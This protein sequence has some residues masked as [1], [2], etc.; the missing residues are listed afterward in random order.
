MLPNAEPR[1]SDIFI[2][3]DR[4]LAVDPDV[5][6]FGSREATQVVDARGC[7]VMPG[8]INAHTHTPMTLTRSTADDAGFPRPGDAP[9]FPPGKDW[10]GRLTAEDHYWSSRLAIAEMIRG[11]TTTFVDMYHDMDRVAQAVADTGIRAALG[12]EIVTFRND[13]REWLPYDE[14]TAR[15]TFEACGQFAADW[16]GKGDGR[17]TALVA[18]HET[19]TCHEPWLSRCARLAGEMN[20][21]ITI[22]VA[23]S[24]WEVGVCQDRYG[25][26]PVQTLERTGILEHRVLGAHSLILTD[27]DIEILAGARYSA[28]AC[29]GC[30]LKLAMGV[31]PVPRLLRAGVNVALGTDGA[32]TN[33]NLN[34]WDEIHLNATLHGFLA[35]D[36]TMIP[37]DSAL[38]MAT[39]GGARALGLE[40]ELGVIAPGWKADLIVLD[41]GRAH[42]APREGALIGNL[43]YSAN[44]SEVRDV[45]VDGRAIM[46]DQRMVAFDET[47]VLREAEAIVRRRRASVGLPH[48]YRR[49]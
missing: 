24:A 37:G 14:R 44:G 25:L 29:L 23:E 33:N 32:A 1:V 27:H 35:Q 16:N 40:K 42:L 41:L 11:G 26:T 3:G 47:E 4:I 49:P 28:V 15:R 7:L 8:L 31:T 17:I 39:V 36:P 10:R 2:E 22:H 9:T 5:P 19:A 38:R 20:L 45:L 21:G 12:S 6:P 18:P 48:Q 43:T 34:M 30:Y 13:A 46:L